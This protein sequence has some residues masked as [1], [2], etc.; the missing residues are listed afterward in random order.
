MYELAY[1]DSADRKRSLFLRLSASL[2]DDFDFAA[3]K[4]PEL[5]ANN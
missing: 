1:H 5:I 3:F 2:R 4:L